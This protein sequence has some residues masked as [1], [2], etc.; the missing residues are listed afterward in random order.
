MTHIHLAWG[1]IPP[2]IKRDRRTVLGRRT[3]MR[4]SDRVRWSY[5]RNPKVAVFAHSWGTG[6]VQVC[7]TPK[8]QS[9]PAHLQNRFM[10]PFPVVTSTIITQSA[11]GLSV[12]L[13]ALRVRGRPDGP[14]PFCMLASCVGKVTVMLRH[15]ISVLSVRIIQWNF[16]LHK[17]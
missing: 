8:Q 6:L 14:C 11:F 10:K 5:V 13:E 3:M 9:W 17:S 1:G 4:S 15:Y 16:F 2:P 12:P 7:A